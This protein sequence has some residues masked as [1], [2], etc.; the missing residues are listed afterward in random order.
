M[1]RGAGR[2]EAR[3]ATA[4]GSERGPGFGTAV[5][6]AA[7]AVGACAAASGQH[8]AMEG[9]E[10]GWQQA[11]SAAL[12]SR[13]AKAATREKQEQRARQPRMERNRLTA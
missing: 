12:S 10:S 11:C 5:G 7:V 1:S 2:S 8:S 4:T 13:A 3:A 9:A 6:E